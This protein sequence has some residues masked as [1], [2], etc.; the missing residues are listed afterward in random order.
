MSMEKCVSDLFAI[1]KRCDR[2]GPMKPPVSRRMILLGLAS[3]CAIA[4][5]VLHANR[6]DQGDAVH[7]SQHR[8]GDADGSSWQNSASFRDLSRLAAQATQGQYFLLGVKDD[9]RPIEWSGQQ[10]RLNAGGTDEAPLSLSLGS[11]TAT[12]DFELATS[13]QDPAPFSMTGNETGPE[14]RPD[15]GGDPFMVLGPQCSNLKINGPRY[16]RSGGRGFFRLDTDGLLSNLVFSGVHAR[17]AGRVIESTDGTLV[18]GLL[19]EDCSAIGLI[20]GFARFRDLSN[21]EFRDLDLDADFL[22]GG[23]NA[24]CQIIKVNRGQDLTF[25]RLRLANAVNILGAE[26]R[27]SSYIQGDGLVLEEG[28]R[29][30]LIEDCH[31]IGMGDGGFDL[32]S[33]GVNMRNCSTVRCKYGIRIWSHD[34]TNLLENCS[35]KEPISWPRNAGSC[36]WVGGT[37]TARDCLLESAGDMSPIRFGSVPDDNAPDPTLRV[38]G[39]EIVFSEGA[40]LIVGEAGTI[41][42]EKVLVNGVET[43]GEFR[44]DG[45]RLAEIR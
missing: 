17:T 3:S 27:G 9:E 38:E 45:D 42:L 2:V 29:A 10:V 13:L 22:D 37:L 4:P 11:I 21:A 19:V 16:D 12:G 1:A 32:K 26:E 35:M 18:E 8:L 20:R 23:G 6:I 40:G 15:V 33:N 14:E 25:R 5:T 30:V 36:L 31:A 24:V 34:S 28:T 44:W 43:S 7:I 39:G 41:I